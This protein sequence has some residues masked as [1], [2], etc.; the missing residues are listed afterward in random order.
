MVSGRARALVGALTSAALAVG[1]A[2]LAAPRADAL[3]TAG[4]LTG[5]VAEGQAGDAVTFRG[6]VPPKRSRPVSLQR[7]TDRWVTVATGSTD[8]DGRFR[9][10]QSIR[11]TTT[12]YRVLAPRKGALRAVATPTFRVRTLSPLSVEQVSRDETGE[13]AAGSSGSPSLSADGRYVAFST[14]APLIAHDTNDEDDV[15][16]RDRRTGALTLVSR[17]L[18]VSLVAN[19]GSSNPEISRDGRYVVFETM[20]TNLGGPDDNGVS[21]VWRWQ[22]GGGLTRIS[23]R[24]EDGAVANG[25]SLYPSISADGRYVSFASDASD[26]GAAS[27]PFMTQVY[28]RDVQTGATDLVSAATDGD[29]GNRDSYVSSIS[30][31]GSRV[32]FESSSSDLVVRD[33]PDTY[34]VF[35]RDL[36]RDA[37]TRLSETATGARGDRESFSPQISGDGRSVVFVS[38]ATNLT[39]TSLPEGKRAFVARVDRPSV[40]LVT[41]FL[42][43]P[44]RVTADAVAVN[45][46]GRYVAYTTPAQADAPDTEPVRDVVVV[47]RER[48]TRTR[49]TV[50]PD[51]RSSDGGVSDV[52]LSGNG[53]FVAYTS[54]ASSL[55]AGEPNGFYDVFVTSLPR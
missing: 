46:N 2:G 16:L 40:R 9:F 48:K 55:T 21:D 17:P 33:A 49:A 39:G 15:Y 45:G 47:D 32:A 51:G 6:A 54:D 42:P 24:P 22:R 31:D 19:G 20:A 53:A 29:A 7:R 3:P 44:A 28:R 5:S 41:S 36:D 8:D 4:A 43:H 27:T 1:L 11:P 50:G 52:V 10:A 26:L 23:S 14:G 18:N 38:R 30:A 13:Q 12:T 37:T 35:V 34:D 25:Q